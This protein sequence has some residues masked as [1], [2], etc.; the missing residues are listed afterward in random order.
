M[1]FKVLSG[2]RLLT[3]LSP[4]M[5]PHGP[6][7]FLCPCDFP[8]KNT[9]VGCHFLLL[10][11]ISFISQLASHHVLKSHLSLL[12]FPLQ[13]KFGVNI[14]ITSMQ[15]QKPTTQLSLKWVAGGDFIIQRE[16][17]PGDTFYSVTDKSYWLTEKYEGIS[18]RNILQGTI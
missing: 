3:K 13:S 14:K 11:F 17:W 12:P 18:L 2:C 16:I 9:G 1:G 6:W 8:G 7:D 15:S 5:R 4:T 10:L